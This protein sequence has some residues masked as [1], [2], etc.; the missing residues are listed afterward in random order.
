MSKGK[1][2]RRAEIAAICSRLRK[3]G[4]KIVS[5]NGVFDILHRG[6]VTY[7]QRAKALGDALIVGLN[8]D[9]S[10]R[11][12]KGPK[13]PINNEK[14]RAQCLAALECVDY[15]VVFGEN[16]PIKIL[17]GIKP[18]IHVKGGDYNGKEGEILEKSVV[19]RNGGKIVLIDMV[20]GYST[21]KL[22]EKIVD[23]YRDKVK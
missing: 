7:L 5:T 18:S 12:I 20:K 4:K 14:A 8:S 17:D 15:V 1:I 22:I 19:E 13:R 6:H 16:D 10:V 21:T 23:A 2:I 11:R 3:Q 9:A